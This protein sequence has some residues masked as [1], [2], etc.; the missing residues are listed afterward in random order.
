M[1]GAGQPPSSMRCLISG[2]AA[3]ASGT[4]TVTR[5]S[6]EPASASSMHCCAVARASAV[7][8]IVIDCTTTGAPPPTWTCPT[9]TP[10]VLW[11][12]TS[13]MEDPMI[14]FAPPGRRNRRELQSAQSN[15][16]LRSL[17]PQRFLREMSRRAMKAIRVHEYGG[18]AV[19]K[20]E[21]V[22][23]PKPG[24]GDVIVRV[25]AA[26]VDPVDAYMHTGTYVRKPPLPYTPGLDGAGEVHTAGADVKNFKP[27]DRVYISG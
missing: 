17:R 21:D 6:S 20:L 10:T 11:S 1:S 22:P 9:F 4:L 12:F 2:T 26:G 24:P 5:T 3:A 23:D 19:L 27:G 7:S 16:S 14:P 8:V 25:R 18:P 15:F 13:C